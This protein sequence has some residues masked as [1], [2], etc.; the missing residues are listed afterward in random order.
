MNGKK[1]SHRWLDEHSNIVVSKSLGCFST[2][3]FLKRGSVYNYN[4]W[5]MKL[6]CYGNENDI[7]EC[8]YSLMSREYYVDWVICFKESEL[9]L[10]NQG[11]YVFD[12]FS[13]I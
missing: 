3:R 1:F 11:L 9:M 13:V 7:K 12:E 5:I 8:K 6:K 4:D 2:D 10:K